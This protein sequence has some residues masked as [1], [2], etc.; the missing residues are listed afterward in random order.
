M[1][2][3]VAWDDSSDDSSTHSE[4]ANFKALIGKT[5][6]SLISSIHSVIEINDAHST[7]SEDEENDSLQEAYNLLLKK[8]AKL[9]RKELDL[10]AR[11]EECEGEISSLKDSLEKSHSELFEAQR[12]NSMLKEKFVI[13]KNECENLVK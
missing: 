6:T 3:R 2:L 12:Q 11:V 5:S 10:T 9:L 13:V 8:A 1:G 7:S 4:S